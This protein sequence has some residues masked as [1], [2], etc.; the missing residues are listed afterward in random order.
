[1]GIIKA[2]R[3]ENPGSFDDIADEFGVSSGTARKIIKKDLEKKVYQKKFHREILDEQRE[4]IIK[5]G[6]SEEPDP[7]YKIAETW[8][9]SRR[10]ATDIIREDLGK[11]EFDRKFNREI[12]DEQREGIIKAGHSEEP[13]SIKK[14]AET[15]GVS[16]GTAIDI[17]KNNLGDKV[18]HMKFPRSEDWV[19]DEQREGIIIAGRLEKPNGISYIAVE[20]KVGPNTAYKIIRNDLGEK[21]FNKKFLNDI[22]QLIGHE[23]HKLIEK[24]ATQDFDEKRKKFPDVPILVSEPPIYTKNN[25]HCDNAFKNDKKYLQKLLKDRI[26]KELKIDPKKLDHIKV[27]I[28]DYTSW[29]HKANL[30]KKI[31]KYQHSEII[32]FIVGTYWF[33]SWIGRVKSLPKDKR[34]KYPE[35]IRIIRWD[36]FADLLN[37][38]NDNRKRFKEIIKLT[39]LKDLETLRRL[40]E[41]NNYK[42][43]RLKKSKARI[44][45]YKSKLDAFLS[46]I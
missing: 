15:W 27:V 16:P 37:L 42:L 36:L 31:E 3:S 11:D 28:F 25:K 44:K 39:R 41:Q 13:D 22:P 30:I 4:D 18:Y 12:S 21:E 20:W 19:S 5:A 6:R 32:F 46:K 45:G 1:M 35:N 10:T 34:I 7:I 40:N 9:V 29:L 2:G 14:I 38:S 33:Q 23:N 24:I 43:H 8:G 17:I 26:A